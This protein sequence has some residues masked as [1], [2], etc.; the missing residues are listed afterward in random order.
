MKAG[1]E[2]A[3]IGSVCKVVAGQSPPGTAYNDQGVGLPFYQG[4]KEFGVREI[5]PPSVWTTVTTK[6]AEQGDILMSVRAP[7]GPVNFSRGRA[8]IGRGLAAIRASGRIDPDFLFYNLWMRQSDIGGKEGA[9][10]ASINRTDIE[11]IEI[12]LPPLKEQRR[13]VEVL[14]EAF[15]AIATA[16][17]NA[18]KNLANARKL[19]SDFLA[20]AFG[21][22]TNNWDIST[23]GETCTLRSGTTVS[24]ELEQPFGEI[25]YVKVAD[26]SYAGNLAEITTSSRF[27]RRSDIGRNATIPA[28][29]TI[30]P[31]RGGAIMTNKKRLVSTPIAAD[32]NIMSVIPGDRLTPRFLN[33]Y[34]QN[35]DMRL[36]GSGSSIP[37]I[38][39]Y[40]IEPLIIAVPDETEQ[41]AFVTK[42]DALKF[43]I[44]KLTETYSRKR[45]A[46]LQ[47]KQSF[48]HCAFTGEL[49]AIAPDLIAA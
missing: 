49:T 19:F 47:L 34:F 25:P 17:A 23:I 7:V 8:C 9:V 42:A 3:T 48:L 38:N 2:T 4:K 29:A 12:P 28:G 39:N 24:S 16:T 1:W 26:M 32:L 27:L 6:V 5:A 41:L 15:A 21:G 45:A 33:Y 44:A 18:E 22:K 30:F 10:F 13:I 20:A 36:L 14:D 43:E 35:V 37:Q 11:S 46:L 31:K 40:D